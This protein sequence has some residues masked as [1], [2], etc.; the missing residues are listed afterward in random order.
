MVKMLY[1]ALPVAPFGTNCYIAGS[2][3]THDGMVI[4]PAGDATRIL[5]NIKE[6]DLKVG[7]IV[8]THNHADHFGAVAA[9]KKATEA[10]FAI[11]RADAEGLQGL[12]A[13][14]FAQFDNEFQ[15]PPP[16]D[17]LLEDG[18]TIKVGDLT[19]SVL[20]TPGH[21]RG[22][23]CIAGYGVVFSG[24]TLFNMGIGRT[25]GPNGDYDQIIRSIESKLMV[26]PD[27]TVVLPGH[28]PKSTIG[29]ERVA[30]PF[31]R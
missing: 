26:L 31:L 20:H 14:R 17:R 2:S 13:S 29:Q 6:L 24:D 25:D 12:G 10:A 4:D 15:P 11:H 23:I 27:Q 7:I 1:R 5:K 22:G 30:N 3:E 19:F 18:D 9:V 28:G 21:S 8:L 16:P